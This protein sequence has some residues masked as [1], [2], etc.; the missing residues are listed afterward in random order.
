MGIMLYINPSLYGYDIPYQTGVFIGALGF[1]LVLFDL[2][3]KIKEKRQ[4]RKAKRNGG[5][6]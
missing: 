1:F 3:K 6:P 5:E 4:T 2:L